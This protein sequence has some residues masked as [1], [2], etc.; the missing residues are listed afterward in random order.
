MSKTIRLVI[1]AAAVSAFA[2]AG[3][4]GP[5]SASHGTHVN[6]AHPTATIAF[7]NP[8]TFTGRWIKDHADFD[9]EIHALDPN[10]TVIYHNSNANITTQQQN[11]DAD[12]AAGVKVIVLAAVDQYEDAPRSRRPRRPASRCWPTTG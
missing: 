2:L 4:A 10:I 9:K 11:V 7:E 6:A 12:I 1:S 3:F 5:V 8:E